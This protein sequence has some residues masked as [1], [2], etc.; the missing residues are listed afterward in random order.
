MNTNLPVVVLKGLATYVPGLYRLRQSRGTSEP[1]WSRYCYSVWLR[2]L[3]M[4]WKH[5]FTRIPESIAE[6]GPGP[7]LGAGLP[8]MITGP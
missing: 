3:V 4:A 6:L 2:H 8:P 1:N 5:G 7:T